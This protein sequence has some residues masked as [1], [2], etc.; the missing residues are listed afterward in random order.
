MRAVHLN[1]EQFD[2]FLY[3]AIARSSAKDEQEMEVAVRV[4]KKLKDPSVTYEE[5]LHHHDV[6]VAKQKGQK[7][8]PFRKLDPPEHTFYL[9]E[10][11]HRLITDRLKEFL[12][13]IS[14][15]AAEEFLDFFLNFKDAPQEEKRLEVQK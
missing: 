7:L 14:L 12:K 9:E 3:P 4:L 15:I 10:E 8:Y 6:E 5:E 13:T 2:N 11:E 1:K